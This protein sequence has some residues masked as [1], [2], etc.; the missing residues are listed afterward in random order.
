MVSYGYPFHSIPRYCPV[1]DPEKNQTRRV[2]LPDRHRSHRR[3]PRGRMDRRYQASIYYRRAIRASSLSVS[4]LPS[5]TM[6]DI[7]LP[8]RELDFR[9]PL[10]RS[11]TVIPPEPSSFHSP[12]NTIPLTTT[13]LTNRASPAVAGVLV[14]RSDPSAGFLT[15]STSEAV[16]YRLSMATMESCVMAPI[17]VHRAYSL[18]SL[19]TGAARS[20]R[21]SRSPVVA[22]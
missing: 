2:A 8:N 17:S 3:I 7:N 16:S 18:P 6:R 5:V 21:H 4:I 22:S 14:N 11:N 19:V 12:T 9:S 15:W 10:A 20:R 1:V 13:G